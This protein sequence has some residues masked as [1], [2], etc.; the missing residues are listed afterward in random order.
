MTRSA[1][2][3]LSQ[4]R[5]T[6]QLKN[7]LKPYSQYVSRHGVPWLPPIPS[8]W[9]IVSNRIAFKETDETNHPNEA[10]LS[11]TIGRGVILQSDLTEGPETDHP[12]TL[13]K[14]QHKLVE[15]DDIVYNKM[16]AWQGAIGASEYRGLI[17][18][19][20][21]VEKTPSGCQRE[22]CWL[23]IPNTHFCCRGP[24]MVV[25]DSV[26]PLETR[27]KDF[28]SIHICLPPAEEQ[29]AIVRY[30]D[31]ADE[32]I[33][34]YISAKER[35]IALLEEQRQAVIQRAV[36]RGLNHQA[37]LQ[38]TH[39]PYIGEIPVHWQ[40][41][42]LKAT[43]KEVADQVTTREP[44]EIYIHLENVESWTG[45]FQDAGPNAT[46]DS[47]V[48]R[49]QPN[50]VL[51]GK[52]RPYLAKVTRPQRKGVCVGEF[53][54]LRPEPTKLH[55][56]YLEQFLLTKPVLNEINSSTFGAKM[57]RADWRFIANLMQPVP[58]MNEQLDICN[59][60][61][62]TKSNIHIGIDRTQRQIA[63]INEYRTRLVA[64]V[65]TGQIDVRHSRPSP[66]TQ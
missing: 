36:T 29:A 56:G 32:L 27:H 15:P 51:F 61:D 11:V 55:P 14:S 53:L 52:L 62:S 59:H 64:D 48:K 20:Y 26:G 50:D 12:I 6:S 2:R 66:S 35:L 30:L 21:V 7:G 24:T 39:V 25:W 5:D 19:D 22:V 17:S 28:K 33:N 60:I 43:V 63:L 37:K 65:V 9:G 38:P 40:T 42:R 44:N 47:A 3:Q 57:P 1:D 45:Q 46:F 18:P 31:H 10:M 41:H 58:P 8:H 49:F 4:K 13:D 34:R 23:L 16:R 54:V